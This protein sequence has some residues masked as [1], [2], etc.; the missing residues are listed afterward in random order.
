M[1]SVAQIINVLYVFRSSP[2]FGVKRVSWLI[3]NS[4]GNSFVS[5]E[6]Q[7]TFHVEQNVKGSVRQVS[8]DAE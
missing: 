1:E 2:W 8:S 4:T 7:K 6:T 3:V 5:V